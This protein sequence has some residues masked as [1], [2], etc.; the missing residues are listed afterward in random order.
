[1]FYQQFTKI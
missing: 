1:M